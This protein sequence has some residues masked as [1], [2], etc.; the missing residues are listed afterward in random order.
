MRRVVEYHAFAQ[1]QWNWRATVD[2]IPCRIAHEG[3]TAYAHRQS[4]IHLRMGQQA[5]KLLAPYYKPA[6]HTNIYAS[7][8]TPPKDHRVTE[9]MFSRRVL[10]YIT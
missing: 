2:S 10:P 6:P 7:T 1:Q 9:S 5:D 8:K 3:L 4:N